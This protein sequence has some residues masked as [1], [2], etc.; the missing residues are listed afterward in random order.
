LLTTAGIRHRSGGLG[1]QPCLHLLPKL[2]IDDPQF[3][4]SAV[5]KLSG[6]ASRLS[7]APVVGSFRVRRRR[8]TFVPA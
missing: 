5:M 4:T 3:W 7:L 2:I 6:F 8:Q 1:Q